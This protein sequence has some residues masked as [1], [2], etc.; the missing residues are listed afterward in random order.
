MTLQTFLEKCFVELEEKDTST[1]VGLRTEMYYVSISID[2]LTNRMTAET[3]A[4][5]RRGPDAFVDLKVDS[6][7]YDPKECINKDS[8]ELGQ[9]SQFPRKGEVNFKYQQ[10]TFKIYVFYPRSDTEKTL[11]NIQIV[12]G[13]GF[14]YFKF[15][16]VIE[17]QNRIVDQNFTPFSTSDEND[18]RKLLAKSRNNFDFTKRDKKNFETETVDPAYDGFSYY[19]VTGN[20]HTLYLFW[21]LDK[22][23]IPS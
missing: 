15:T 1:R 17:E 10:N 16:P 23:W 3:R 14:D 6:Y 9:N 12:P 5:C 7:D 19:C 2:T 21:H 20:V 13:A 4:T 8:E 11:R 22:E 18:A